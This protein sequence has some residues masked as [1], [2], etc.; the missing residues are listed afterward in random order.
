MQHAINVLV[1]NNS[2]SSLS[3][4]AL[5]YSVISKGKWIKLKGATI[6]FDSEI[7]WQV[8]VTMQYLDCICKPNLAMSR[9]G[10]RSQVSIFAWQ[11][12]ISRRALQKNMLTSKCTWLWWHPQHWDYCFQYILH[13]FSQVLARKEML[14]TL[15]RVIHANHMSAKGDCK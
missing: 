2:I 14:D 4:T 11:L 12:Y 10:T 13:D 15:G 6:L 9:C 8:F 1:N 5:D 7:Q 3:F